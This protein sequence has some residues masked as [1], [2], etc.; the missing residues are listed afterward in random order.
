VELTSDQILP[1]DINL[2]EHLVYEKPARGVG[3]RLALEIDDRR[4]SYA[5]LTRDTQALASVL[6]RHGVE[7]GDRVAIVLGD[8]ETFALAF[9]AILHLGAVAVPLNPSYAREDFD[10]L[11]ARLEPKLAIVQEE[12]HHKIAGTTR[13]PLLQASGNLQQPGEVETDLIAARGTPAP[14]IVRD[15]DRVAYILHSSGTT[16]PPKSIPH[17]HED[18]IHC[19]K[20][21]AIAILG[22][23]AD[24]RVLAVPKLTFGYGLGGN[25]LS[26]LYVGGCSILVRQLSSPDVMRDAARRF[27]PTLFLAQPRTLVGVLQ[28]GDPDVFS[29]LRLAVSAGEVLAPSL[30]QK[31][32]DATSVELLDGFGST[33][34]GHVFISNVPGKVVPGSAG[35]VVPGFEVSIVDEAGEL[36]PPETP[37]Q[38]LVRG[39]SLAACYYRD[40]ERTADVFVD[41]WVRTGD[42]FRA[43]RDGNHFA[44]GRAD[45]MIKVGCGEWVS[46]IELEMWLSTD[47]AVADCAV[48]AWQDADGILRVKAHVVLTNGLR[49]VSTITDRL[50]ALVRRRAQEM[51]HKQLAAVD[52]V[53]AL[54]RSANG[55][56]Q[57]SR[58]GAVSMT[59]YSY[60]C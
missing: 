19:I 8:C 51:T 28:L 35:R 34:V 24:D 2:A 20:A 3:A 39:P 18:I 57:R 25:L 59:E 9:F 46:P 36:V 21:Y 43:D 38:L 37:G 54:P 23:T 47:P 30:R 15:S 56:L 16:G 13:F 1:R 29:E 12:S 33:E 50:T 17:R 60:S 55:K 10:L 11:F 7:S 5:E 45:D 6:E 32:L 41:G 22:M 58:L 42:V 44:L 14:A 26:S 27:R 52:Y 49:P 53:S 40:P 31:W 48:S 4:I